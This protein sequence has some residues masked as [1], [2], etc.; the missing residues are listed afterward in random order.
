[1]QFTTKL[2]NTIVCT[3]Q[4]TYVWNHSLILIVVCGYF[5]IWGKCKPNM[6]RV[7]KWRSWGVGMKAMAW[8]KTQ[9]GTHVEAIDQY[10]VFWCWHT[11]T[12][13]ISRQWTYIY[14]RHVASYWYGEYLRK[15]EKSHDIYVLCNQ[16]IQI[17]FLNRKRRKKTSSTN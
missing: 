6:K 4:Q 1:M 16:K 15:C 8:R 11:C 13:T 2:H 9:K 5:H 17:A 3:G 14:R 12:V 7:G 10:R